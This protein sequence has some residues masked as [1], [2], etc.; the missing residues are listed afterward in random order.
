MRS[1]LLPPEQLPAASAAEAAVWCCDRMDLLKTGGSGLLLHAH[2]RS[3]AA[4]SLLP[5]AQ[6]CC[7][8]LTDALR[9]GTAVVACCCEQLVD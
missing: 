5:A 7:C 1:C 8:S 3:T 4:G 2:G 6:L 9:H